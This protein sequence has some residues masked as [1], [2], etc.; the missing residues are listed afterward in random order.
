MIDTPDDLLLL[1]AEHL[2]RDLLLDVDDGQRAVASL[3]NGWAPV[4]LASATFYASQTVNPFSQV[5][6]ICRGIRRDAQDWIVPG[7]PD[8]RLDRI[9]ELLEDVASAP[10]GSGNLP[11]RQTSA[12]HTCYLATH[13][14]AGAI[15][16]Y[17]AEFRQD[18]STRPQGLLITALGSR[19]QH[20]E[21]I[22]TPTSV[23][24]PQLPAQPS[25]QHRR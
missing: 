21:Q 9:R 5:L 23:T 14:V 22:S 12:L 18:E 11:R 10:Q 16:R 24:E 25:G 3:L 20:A 4:I 13:A 17:A 7:R 1:E 15:A 6:E 2:A 8:P 19:I